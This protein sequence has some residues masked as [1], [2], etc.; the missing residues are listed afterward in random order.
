MSNLK[1]L[2]STGNTNKNSV[3]SS[4]NFRQNKIKPE[5]NDVTIIDEEQPPAESV[6]ISK[7]ISVKNN[8]LN[9]L[10]LPSA[11]SVESVCAELSFESQ[12]VM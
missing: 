7:Q 8:A 4:P 11:I 2:T 6:S 3:M 9:F 1:I 5:L 10:P 12:V